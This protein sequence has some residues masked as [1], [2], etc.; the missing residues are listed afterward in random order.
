MFEVK[1][2][3]KE[4]PLSGLISLGGGAGGLSAI[5]GSG[6]IQQLR[7][8]HANGTEEDIGEKSSHIFQDGDII[9][10][11]L[12]DYTV[13]IKCAGQR[14]HGGASSSGA[15]KGGLGAWVKGTIEMKYGAKYY[16]RVSDGIGAIYWGDSGEIEHFFLG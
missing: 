13:V 1:W 15:D 8:L 6:A 10:P 5:S 9:E 4:M 16:V 11:I 12:A 2:Q 14:G 3:R 7:V